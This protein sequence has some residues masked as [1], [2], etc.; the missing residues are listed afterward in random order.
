M[1]L[2]IEAPGWFLWTMVAV[3][4]IVLAMQLYMKYLTSKI[5]ATKLTHLILK[6]IVDSQQGSKDE[7][8]I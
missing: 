5:Y 8:E 2:I 3:I 7:K 6:K 4:Y 1:K